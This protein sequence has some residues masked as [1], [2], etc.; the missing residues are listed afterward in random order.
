MK[1]PFREQTKEGEELLFPRTSLYHPT[2]YVYLYV[3]IYTYPYTRDNIIRCTDLRKIL[4]TLNRK[5]IHI[6][7]SEALGGCGGIKKIITTRKEDVRERNRSFPRG[8]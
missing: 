7:F 5:Y 8:K 2:I 3:H 4:P 1:P 6:I